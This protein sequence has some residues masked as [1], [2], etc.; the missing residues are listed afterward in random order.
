MPHYIYK[1][2][3][4]NQ[5]GTLL[6]MKSA[7]ASSEKKISS[8]TCNSMILSNK[9]R[10]KHNK[11]TQTREHNSRKRMSAPRASSL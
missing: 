9:Q 3:V 2:Y 6:Q 1:L 7:F 8:I 4:I 5:V 10:Q 11:L